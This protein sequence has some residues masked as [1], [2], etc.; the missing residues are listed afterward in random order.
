METY[1]FGD[2]LAHLTGNTIVL[3]TVVTETY[4]Q[5]MIEYCSRGHC[6][7]SIPPHVIGDHFKVVRETAEFAVVELKDRPILTDPYRGYLTR[8]YSLVRDGDAWRVSGMYLDCDGYLPDR[9]K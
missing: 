2:G 7:G 1:Y 4:L 6:D 9:Y 8:C 5:D 3:E